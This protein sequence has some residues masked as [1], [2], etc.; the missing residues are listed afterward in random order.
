MALLPQGRWKH[1]SDADKCGL[2]ELAHVEGPSIEN[3][4]QVENA[5]TNIALCTSKSNSLCFAG[6]ALHHSKFLVSALQGA[7]MQSLPKII[8][9]DVIMVA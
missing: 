1:S 8:V 5:S 6:S 4:E 9:G 3:P 2:F 7:D